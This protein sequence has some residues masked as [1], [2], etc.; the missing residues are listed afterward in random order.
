MLFKELALFYDRLESVPS[1]LKMIEI[2]NETFKAAKPSEVEHII[3]ITQGVLAPPFEG[4]EF[5]VADK[6]VEEAIAIATGYSKADVES[7]YRKAGDLGDVAKQL[8][9][10]TKL[11][12]MRSQQ[13]TVEE[14]YEKMK[15]LALTSGEG[16][17]AQKIHLLA[18][19]IAN[20]SPEEVKYI[21]RYPLGELRMGV[22]DATILEALALSY[23]GSRS[24][25]PSLE[26]AY[27][28]CSDL[29][30][31]GKVIA[32]EGTSA[33][34][35]F[36]VTIFK[37]IRPALAE[38]LPTAKEILEKMHGKAAVEQKYDGFRLQVHKNGNDV[39]L[40]SRRLE[41]TTEMF[42]DIIEAVRKEIP[43]K[44]VIF[45]GEAIAF[46]EVTGELFPFQETIQRKRKH[47][48]DKKAEELPLH[49]FAFDI[50]YNEGEDLLS[51]PYEER[52]ALLEKL[53]HNSTTIRPTTRIITDSPKE[54][55]EFFE[56]SIEAGLEGIVA[57]DLHAPYIA[58]ARKFSWI[59]MKRSYKGELNDTLDL[60]IV[61]YYLGK[62]G[63]AEFEFGGLLCAVYNKKR[64]MFET[65][66]KLGTGFTE[67]QM[68]ELKTM[69][70]KIQVKSKPARVD[71]IIEP[72]FWV[73]PKYVVVV[74]ADEI[75]KSPTHTCGR[76]K[77]PD[78]TEVGYALRFPRLVGNETVRSDKSAEDAT[79]TSEVIEMYNQQKKVKIEDS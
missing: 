23:A 31:V 21:V 59:K 78:G 49:L 54:L 34:E 77:Q 32:S 19:M 40:F 76:E 24:F 66:T 46:N 61:G 79:T 35:G 18:D 47:D 38:R 45:E 68:H 70:Q 48:I 11:K 51:K 44:R 8:K 30:Y 56:R 71:S 6:L 14:I 15:N 58:G 57:K 73:T 69:L 42:P 10:S 7:L 12:S 63:R 1:R 74:K 41:N 4:I 75:T 62:G 36:K 17:K 25:K 67:A 28:I 65:I 5:G 43:A 16:S 3:Y 50:M 2:L 27:N 29:G 20:S 60:V 55:E 9:S 52:R 22:G 72:D 33:I 64:D 37:P 13:Y 26:R 53:L 39:K